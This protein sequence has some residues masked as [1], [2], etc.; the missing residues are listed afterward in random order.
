MSD[1]IQQFFWG[2]GGGN[3]C[4]SVHVQQL[5]NWTVQP[6]Q[7]EVDGIEALLHAPGPVI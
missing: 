3:Q 1:C 6:G 4:S 7:E 5:A 2:G